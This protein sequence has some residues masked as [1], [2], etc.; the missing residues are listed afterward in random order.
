STAS[1]FLLD[2]AIN[3][4]SLAVGSAG[5]VTSSTAYGL[6]LNQFSIS[7]GGF[8]RTAGGNGSAANPYIITDVFGLQGIGSTTA[9]LSANYYLANNIDASS[10]ANWNN[11][12]GFVPLGMG[13]GTFTGSLT[14][15]INAWNAG[16]PV[17]ISFLT[18][19]RSTTDNVGMFSRLGNIA[20]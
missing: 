2:R 16:T 12:A 3:A 4:N 19:N 17:T 14:A 5:L 9:L 1:S 6:Q 20:S 13:V 8:L 15:S 11:G 18:I 10:T 7:G